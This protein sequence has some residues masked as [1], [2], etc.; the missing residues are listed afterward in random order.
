MK[1]DILRQIR[2]EE[3][4]DL[5]SELIRIPS[6]T[7]RE[8]PAAE[9]MRDF[10]EDRGFETDMQEVQPGR[11]QVVARLMGSGGGRSMMFNG[12]LDIDPLTVSWGWDPFEPRVEGN[13][14]WGAGVHNMKSGVAAMTMAA[15]ALERSGVELKGDLVVA[16]VVGEL[17]GGLGTVYLVNSGVRTD[18]AIVPE[19]YSVENILTKSVGVH[20]FAIN[21]IG[22]SEHIS[23]M[24]ESVDAI[25]KMMKVME[26]IKHLEFDVFDPDLPGAPRW[27]VG[28]IIGGRSREYDLA[29][30]YNIPDVCTI[31][32]DFRYPPGLTIEAVN[33]KVVE[34]LEE[35]RAEDPE[36]RYEFEYPVNPRFRVGGVVMP[37]MGISPNAEVVQILKE[38]HK[39]VTGEYPKR[40]GAVPPYSYCGNDTAH[41]ERAG[42]ECCLYGPRGYPDEVEKHVRIDEMVTC[43][44]SLALTAAEVCTSKR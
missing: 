33:A 17:Q 1:A 29:G 25:Q 23:R 16:C 18:M 10:F 43:A 15:V 22:S 28:S 21:V 38:N 5:A 3:V 8:T 2:E 35:I 26:R 40:I 7:E 31:I 11:K 13:K 19:P 36:F 42:I 44:K 37:P 30:P 24:E 27:I 12:H 9:F 14:L 6:F 39:H 20:D 34:M 32:V 41:L 4:V